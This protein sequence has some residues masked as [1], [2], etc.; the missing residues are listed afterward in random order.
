MIVKVLYHD[1][2]TCHGRVNPEMK[3]PT[4][5]G[6]GGRVVLFMKA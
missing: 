2:G 1:I 3:K 6:A 5:W 4:G